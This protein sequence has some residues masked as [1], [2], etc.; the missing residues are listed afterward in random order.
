MGGPS[1]PGGAVSHIKQKEGSRKDY[2][3][4]DEDESNK[5]DVVYVKGEPVITTGSDVSRF[6]VD[7]QDD[8]DP[9]LTFHLLFI[10]TVC[11]CLGATLYQICLFKPLQV[12]VSVVFLLLFVYSAGSAWLKIPPWHESV[13]RT[14]FAKLG[15]VL[16]FINPGEFRIKEVSHHLRCCLRQQNPCLMVVIALVFVITGESPQTCQTDFSFWFNVHTTPNKAKN[17]VML[18]SHKLRN[19]RT[20]VKQGDLEEAQTSFS[21]CFST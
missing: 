7:V 15:P 11:A 16:E 17:S 20:L 9:A 21:L 4:L 18:R 5:D 3:D 2:P 12:S 10:G 14:R 1:L 6:L 19:A 8:G 13:E